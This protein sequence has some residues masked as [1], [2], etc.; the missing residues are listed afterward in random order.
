MNIELNCM[1]ISPTLSNFMSHIQHLYEQGLINKDERNDKALNE[2]IVFLEDNDI[3]LLNIVHI[4]S[5]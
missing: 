2:L 4:I 3:K 5:E 1:Q